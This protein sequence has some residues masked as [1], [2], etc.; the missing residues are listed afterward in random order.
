MAFAIFVG[1]V[2]S[3]LVVAEHAHATLGTVEC[4]V[5]V[6]R[7]QLI[8][9]LD[10]RIGRAHFGCRWCHVRSASSLVHQP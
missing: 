1:F 3:G 2:A 10:A 6:R 4:F 7:E 8:F 5:T 9:G